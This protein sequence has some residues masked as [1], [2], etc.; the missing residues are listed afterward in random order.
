[1]DSPIADFLYADDTAVFAEATRQ[2]EADDSHTV[3][4]RFRLRVDSSSVASNDDDSGED[5]YEIMEGKG[6][7]MLD[8]LGGGPSHT[9][10]VVRPAPLSIDT[11]QG[12]D[13]IYSREVT[14]S[15]H[16]GSTSEQPPPSINHSSTK[17][18]LCRICDRPT[19]AWFFEK[20][21]ETCNETHRLEHDIIECNDRL[22]DIAKTVDEIVATLA[23]KDVT[24]PAEYRGIL[25]LTPTPTPTPPTALEGL[26]FPFSPV[27]PQSYA[28]RKA[29]NKIFDQ[30][31]DIIHIALDISTPSALDEVDSLPIENQRLLSPNV[32]CLF[33]IVFFAVSLTCLAWICPSRRINL[34]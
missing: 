7:L 3:E 27:K 13:G 15:T 18:I 25:L 8:G 1:L 19:P 5:F 4:V 29:Q 20:H 16:R 28:V 10:W 2:L 31:S 11:D 22:K 34:D 32:S 17:S 12:K 33:R 6:M 26:R 9:M 23:K 21:N 30:V 24:V 14:I